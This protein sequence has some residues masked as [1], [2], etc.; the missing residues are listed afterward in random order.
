MHRLLQIASNTQRILEGSVEKRK[1]MIAVQS[2]ENKSA[3]R[4]LEVRAIKLHGRRVRYTRV[5]VTHRMTHDFP[6]LMSVY[7][8]KRVATF[9]SWAAH[10]SAFV[11]TWKKIKMRGEKIKTEREREKEKWMSIR[12]SNYR[13]CFH[14]PAQIS[15]VFRKTLLTI[16]S[17]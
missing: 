10:E 8:Q 13:V 2:T 4:I 7:I 6:T 11:L 9:E 5:I 17:I 3:L 16:L 15:V 14:E 1:E 12:H